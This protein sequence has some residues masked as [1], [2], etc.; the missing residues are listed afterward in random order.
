M[1]NDA[2]TAAG[3]IAKWLGIDYTPKKL[4]YP[5][6]DGKTPNQHSTES[7]R[8]TK[9]SISSTVR[10]HSITNE[11][12]ETVRVE[13]T[14]DRKEEPKPVR[15]EEPPQKKVESKPAKREEPSK[16]KRE[17]RAFA[18]ESAEV[19]GYLD[20]P[21]PVF[22]MDMNDP[23]ADLITLDRSFSD[24]IR[25]LFT[26]P[27]EEGAKKLYFDRPYFRALTGKVADDYQMYLD[28]R[29]NYANS[30]AFYFDMAGWFYKHNDKEIA[31]RILTSIAELELEDAMLYRMLA[32]RLKE[33]GEYALQK[34]V[35]KKVL[36]WR[37]MEPQ[38]YRDYALALADNGET[39][40]ALDSL[41]S[42]LTRPFSTNIARR[43]RIEEVVVTEINHLLA[44]HPNLSSSKI[45]ERVLLDIPV[46]ARVVLNWNMDNVRI[47]LY[48][49]GPDGKDYT[50]NTRKSIGVAGY[51]PEQIMLKDAIKGRYTVYAEY[52]SAREF[53]APGPVTVM[54]EI[55]TKYA[56]KTEQRRVV[57]QQLSRG[58]ERGRGR[59]VI[60]T[61]FELDVP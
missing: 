56:D 16:D 14:S 61:E 8:A 7:S 4:K 30:P 3:N 27:S 55:Y 5:V 31:L 19:I 24:N 48:L 2:V 40:A 29:K 42:L 47:G 22:I 52:H 10:G 33:Y 54:L 17:S 28:I 23:D 45:D 13:E 51:G 58:W 50:P 15:K 18:F 12:R 41:Y 20:N 11:R 37:P 6:P 1:L 49:R 39:Q 32:Y 26:H 21:T 34:F 57:T 25:Y 36:E 46:D 35:T 44:K 59:T 38:S 9:D 53:A 60:A 43:N